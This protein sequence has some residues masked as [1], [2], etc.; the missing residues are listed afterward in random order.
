MLGPVRLRNAI[1]ASPEK[2]M[3]QAYARRNPI[4]VQPVSFQGAD[5]DARTSLD[6]F[7]DR[8][9]NNHIVV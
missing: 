8:K 4:R 5:P 6:V 7:L 9:L 1:Q 2:F 3:C